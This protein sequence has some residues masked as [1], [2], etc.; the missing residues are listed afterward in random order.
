MIVSEI[1]GD[2]VLT[3]QIGEPPGY[4]KLKKLAEKIFLNFHS[5]LRIIERDNVCSCGACTGASDLTLKFITHFGKL[6][7]IDVANFKKIIGSDVILVHR[8]LK[9]Q[10][11]VK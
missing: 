1:E 3:Y 10:C 4:D 8:L 2:A 5:Q 9:K 6:K 7:E 11:S